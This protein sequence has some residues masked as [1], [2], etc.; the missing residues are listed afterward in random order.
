[1]QK[2]IFLDI[3]GPMIPDPLYSINGQVS[4]QRSHMSTCAVGL[5]TR[6]CEKYNALIVTN[7]AHNGHI[8]D[9][10]FDLKTDLISHGLQ[11]EFFH[12]NWHTNFAIQ[13]WDKGISDR[14]LAINH[15]ISQ[16]GESDWVCFDDIQFTQDKRLILIDFHLGI[17]Y[18]SYKS[19]LEI[20]K[21]AQSRFII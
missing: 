8:R 14:M 5:L 15:W 9:G 12:E 18:N 2:I 6:I 17:D 1:M 20:W 3:D 13:D 21:I 10:V 11:P 7:T 4:I 16:N 19:A